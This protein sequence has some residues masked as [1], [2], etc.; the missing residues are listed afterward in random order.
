[1]TKRLRTADTMPTLV[2]ERL[3]TWGQCVRKRVQ[4]NIAPLLDALLRN[5]MQER[6]HTMLA[7]LGKTPSIR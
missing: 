2:N 3:R 7:R 6:L 1:M 5:A 4:Q